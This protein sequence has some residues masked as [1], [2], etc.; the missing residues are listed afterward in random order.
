MFA[1]L[2]PARVL[3]L[4]FSSIAFIQK[5]LKKFDLG[6]SLENFITCIYSLV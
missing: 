3:L 5:S 1:R 6:C 2:V 4:T